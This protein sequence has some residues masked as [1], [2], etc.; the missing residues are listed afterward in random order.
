MRFIMT[1][2]TP[3]FAIAIVLFT[4][5]TKILIFP[6]QLKSK[7]GM[8][9]Q[10]RIQPKL[11]KLQKKYGN[12]KQKY[13][14]EVQKLYKQEKVSLMGGCLPTILMLVVLLGL[15]GVI[16]RPLT[17]LMGL[18]G[19]VTAVAE[20]LGMDT[21]VKNLSE[22]TAASL[23]SSR[24]GEFIGDYPKIFAIDFRFLGLDL[25]GMPSYNPFNLLAMLPIISAV[26]AFGTSWLNRKFNPP[27]GGAEGQAATTGKTMMIIMPL[28]SLWIGFMLPSGVTLYWIV[29]NLLS[30]AQEPLLK[31][32]AE[33]KYGKIIIEPERDEPPKPVYRKKKPVVYVEDDT[34]YDNID[35]QKYIEEEAAKDSAEAAAKEKGENK[36][37]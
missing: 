19:Q 5:I 7:K 14:E 18:K 22:I 31:I 1:A 30:S 9:D 33:K 34:D 16:Y 28:I 36:T 32:V 21:S 20:A 26:T 23:L 3:N 29:N 11:Q 37:K 4:V 24:I 15:Y 13:N 25:S 10:Q 12:D 17:Y 8:L 27:A 2:I 6:L 35:I